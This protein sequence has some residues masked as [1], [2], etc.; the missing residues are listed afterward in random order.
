R[1]PADSTVRLRRFTS[2]CRYSVRTTGHVA[3]AAGVQR[4]VLT[5]FREGTNARL[6]MIEAHV[7]TDFKGQVELALDL[8]VFPV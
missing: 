7:R 6:P 1:G 5:H 2:G 3:R 8:D 4:M